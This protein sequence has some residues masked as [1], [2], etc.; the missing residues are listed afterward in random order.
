MANMRNHE[1]TETWRDKTNPDYT[2]H[3]TKNDRVVR[4]F[5]NGR[6]SVKVLHIEDATPTSRAIFNWIG[7]GRRA[8]AAEYRS[9]LESRS[10]RVR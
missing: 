10:E 7:R 8:T 6:A 2:Y 4:M 1:V 3:V 9:I 5:K